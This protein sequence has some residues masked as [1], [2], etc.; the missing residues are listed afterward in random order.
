VIY[1]LPIYP[2]RKQELQ[3][4]SFP[5]IKFKY[6]YKSLKKLSNKLLKSEYM[7]RY[8]RILKTKKQSASNASKE[9]S[10]AALFRE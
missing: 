1:A 8:N 3:Q 9:S 2:Q 6:L 10:F 5:H 7:H 4:Q